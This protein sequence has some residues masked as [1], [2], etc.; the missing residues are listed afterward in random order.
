MLKGTRRFVVIEAVDKAQSLV[1]ELLRLRIVRGNRVME[2]A[3]PG[4]ERH[5]TGFGVGRG[6]G[7]VVLR[8]HGQAE[9][10][11]AHNGSQNFHLVILL[12]VVLVQVARSAGGKRHCGKDAPCK[13]ATAYAKLGVVAKKLSRGANESCQMLH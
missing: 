1:K 3:Q 7:S 10:Y 9:K 6:V 11:C 4:H 2:I 5:R 13:L 12:N 8:C